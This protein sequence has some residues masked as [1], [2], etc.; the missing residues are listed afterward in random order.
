MLGK[1]LKKGFYS[2]ST[3]ELFHKIKRSAL[4]SPICFPYAVNMK[5]T[6][7]SPAA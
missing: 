1:P 3:N 2:S 6:N 5:D 4:L 7:N